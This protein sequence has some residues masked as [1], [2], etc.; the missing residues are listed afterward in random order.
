MPAKRTTGS[1]N[2][3]KKVDYYETVGEALMVVGGNRVDS[4]DGYE[5]LRK[6]DPKLPPKPETYYVGVRGFGS[7]LKRSL[8]YRPV[9]A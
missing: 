8:Q 4:V 2:H 6:K 9:T 5:L 3:S 1:K 7:F